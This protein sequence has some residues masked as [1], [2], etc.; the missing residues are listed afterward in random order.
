MRIALVYDRIN[1]FGG[2]ERVLLALHEIWP[3]APLFTSVY[4]P[5]RASWADGF[6]VIPSFLNKLP[7]ARSRH[8]ILPWLMPLAFES[9]E[10]DEFDVVI[11]ITSEF[12]KGI[13]T[14]PHTFHLCYCLTPTRYLWSGYEDY[15][16]NR[17]FKFFSQPVV[18]YLRTWDKIASQRPDEYLAISQEVK[19]RIKKY[20]DRDSAVIYPPHAL[21]LGIVTTI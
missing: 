7:L 1:K 10:F 2:A 12:A 21:V 4:H 5:Q 13:I 18:S 6:K 15:F 16:Q 3:D 17:A 20:Y 14:K 8:E 9:F 11:S 19:K